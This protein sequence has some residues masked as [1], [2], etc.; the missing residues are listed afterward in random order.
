MPPP[1]GCLRTAPTGERTSGVPSGDHWDLMLLVLV[2]AVSLR[3]LDG[4]SALRA[5][6]TA[7]GSGRYTNTGHGQWTLVHFIREVDDVQVI[8]SSSS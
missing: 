2:P 4:T 6:D 7:S 8:I 1:S 3:D 5:H